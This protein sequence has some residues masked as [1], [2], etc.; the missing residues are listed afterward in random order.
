MPRNVRPVG[1]D[2]RL[3]S[4]MDANFGDASFDLYHPVNVYLPL[5][6]TPSSG[7]SFNLYDEYQASNYS[8]PS[9]EVDYFGASGFSTPMSGLDLLDDNASEPNLDWDSSLA[10]F[11]DSVEAAALGSGSNPS[12]LES[13]LIQ[14][15]DFS[16]PEPWAARG[17]VS[18]DSSRRIL[19]PPTGPGPGPRISLGENRSELTGLIKIC[20][21]Q[22]ALPSPPFA[23]SGKGENKH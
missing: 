9:S 18:N 6:A 20:G 12:F 15:A 2:P 4:G 1:L 3:S 17:S 8:G 7:Y 19:F 11:F 5:S 10:S 16:P 22:A 14:P 23:H 13:N 21:L